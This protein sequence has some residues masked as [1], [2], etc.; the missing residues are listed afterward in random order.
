MMI[1]AV[2]RSRA[3]SLEYAERLNAYGVAA[4]TV[5]TPKE[6]KIGC[7]LCVR[8][9]ARYFYR[10]QALLKTGGYSSFKGFYKMEFFNGKLS[11][12]P[13]KKMG[14]GG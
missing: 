12:T 11:V 13:Y 5:P 2:F 9:D 4:T 10:A 8:F 6:A 7:G 3:N 1:L 14:G